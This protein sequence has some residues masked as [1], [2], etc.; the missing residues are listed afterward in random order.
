MNCNRHLSTCPWNRA[1]SVR[2]SA[3]LTPTSTPGVLAC[4]SDV[5][6]Q[7]SNCTR[8]HSPERDNTRNGVSDVTAPAGGPSG[9][10][11]SVVRRF[12]WA[13]DGSTAVESLAG[14]VTG[15]ATPRRRP[16]V[17][18]AVVVS[19]SPAGVVVVLTLANGNSDARFIQPWR[20]TRTQRVCVATCFK[21]K[22]FAR[23]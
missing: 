14:G 16:G 18:P 8:A 21:P 2:S 13:L 17:S 3:A 1:G 7:P 22:P 19:E 23:W 6:T 15:G 11:Y 10:R 20:C 12:G 4:R 9:A 5:L